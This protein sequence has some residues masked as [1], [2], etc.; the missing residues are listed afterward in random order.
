MNLVIFVRQLREAHLVHHLH[1]SH[2]NVG[3]QGAHQL[4][5]GVTNESV[6]RIIVCSTEC[7]VE[8][9][10]EQ[11]SVGQREEKFD[12]FKDRHPLSRLF[13]PHGSSRVLQWNKYST[14]MP[15]K[16]LSFN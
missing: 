16:L 14:I 6:R 3:Q 11:L 15:E 10:V 1:S 9:F 4:Q 8:H 7:F 12:R 5:T 2:V 13:G